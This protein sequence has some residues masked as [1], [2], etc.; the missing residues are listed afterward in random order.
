MVLR[1]ISSSGAYL[2][3]GGASGIGAATVSLLHAHGA[4]VIFGDISFSA[5]E[6]IQRRLGPTVHFVRCDVS[7]YTENV[8]LFKTALSIYGRV[9]HAIA[10]AGVT[11]VGNW[12]SGKLSE[13]DV[14]TAPDSM[15]LDVNLKAVMWF[16]R[17]AVVYL[18]KGN[19][20]DRSLTLLSSVA[21][22]TEAPGLWAYQA[23]K[24]GVLGLM[25]A[26]RCYLPDTSDNIRVNAVCPWMTKTRM[27][28]GIQDG[29]LKAGLPTNTPEDVA[30]HVAGLVAA[31]PGSQHL[32]RHD[33]EEGD[34]GRGENAGA[35][36]WG[37]FEE[38]RG[39]SG[40]AIYVEGGRGWDIEEGLCRTQSLWMGRGPTERFQ[41]GQIELGTGSDWI[42]SKM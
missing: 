25:R 5:G 4:L 2:N 33:P 38:R 23:A 16:A 24:C 9:D 42:A 7:N 13:D 12:L 31:G 40:R 21:G 30:W 34:A 8:L 15:T 18:R 6:A 41:R 20:G 1:I 36:Q 32:L 37:Q 28:A 29:W 22:F 19:G 14:E 11:E 17:I 26:L 27:V 3:P 39:I 35:L 10:N